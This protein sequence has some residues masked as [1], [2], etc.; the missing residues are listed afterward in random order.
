VSVSKVTPIY[1]NKQDILE[2][3]N[4]PNLPL[5]A[6]ICMDRQADIVVTTFYQIWTSFHWIKSGRGRHEYIYG[7]GHRNVDI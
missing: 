4:E 6:F 1:Q 3:T 2:R 7:W 5:N